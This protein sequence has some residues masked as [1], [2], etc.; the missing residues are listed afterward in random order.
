MLRLG[1]D[2]GRLGGAVLVR[3]NG[4]RWQV[5]KVAIFDNRWNEKTQ[6]SFDQALIRSH[7]QIKAFLL[8]VIDLR[9]D[10]EAIIVNIESPEEFNKARISNVQSFARLNQMV[11]SARIAAL[12]VAESYP[13]IA[14]SA[15]NPLAAKRAVLRPCDIRKEPRNKMGKEKVIVRAKML[16]IWNGIWNWSKEVK[17]RAK[18]NGK[19]VPNERSE[20]V[21]DA[22]SIA[23]VGA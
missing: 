19:R 22:F 13:Y 1:I 15:I 18:K 8:Q 2:C 3:K 16:G 12:E 23:L 11:A 14:V 5:L 20:T 10:N 17:P 21:G 9:E 6:I 7:H 4:D